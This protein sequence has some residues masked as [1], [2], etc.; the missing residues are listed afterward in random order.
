[1][2]DDVIRNFE[3]G[4][5]LISLTSPHN[6]TGAI[7]EVEQLN[8]IIQFAEKQNCYVVLD[9]TY[10]YLTGKNHQF[11]RLSERVIVIS[12]VSKAFGV[13]GIRIG[14]IECKNRE[15]NERFL[16]SKEQIHICNS[17]VDESIALEVLKRKNQI[18]PTLIRQIELKKSMVADWMNTQPELEWNEPCEG[19]VAYPRFKKGS[20][21]DLELFY[22]EL[23][24]TYKTMV[25]PGHWFGM[26][27]S[28]FR[29]G[30]GWPSE[31]ELMAGLKNIDLCIRDCKRY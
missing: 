22:T 11:A 21:V 7:I 25:G 17:V 2:A 5:K 14:W 31:E 8:K 12:S 20:K 30:F 24:N 16:A 18:L 15:L 26:E 19:V 23:M 3:K 9:E 27:K 13:P 1:L 10:R 6:P 4:T 29:L 28:N